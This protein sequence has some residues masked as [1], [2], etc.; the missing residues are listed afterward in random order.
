MTV[1]LVTSIADRIKPLLAGQSPDVQGAVLADLLAI[2]LAGHHVEGDE[3]ATR[4]LRAELLA[5]HCFAVRQLVLVNAKIM[6]TTN[7]GC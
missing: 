5:D 1:A 2:W 6:G 3:N 7:N 4:T